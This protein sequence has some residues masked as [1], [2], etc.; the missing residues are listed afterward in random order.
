MTGQLPLV[1]GVRDN[2]VVSRLGPGADAGPRG[3]RTRAIAPARSSA[4]TCSIAASGWSV[5][6]D[7]YD[8]RVKRDPVGGAR[9]EAERRGEVVDAALSR[10]WTQTTH[11]FLPVGASLRSACALR[12]AAGVPAKAG[13]NAYD[14]E[15]AFADAQVA[16]LLEYWLGA[17]RARLGRSSPSPATTARDWAITASMTHG[18]LAYDSTLRVPLVLS[19]AAVPTRVVTAPVSLAESRAELLRAAGLNTAGPSADL[20]APT[21]AER[22]V[23][24]GDG[25]PARRGGMRCRYSQASAGS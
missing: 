24:R 5:G 16:R 11:P 8:D 17:R 7:T 23:Y 12:S 14:G 6:F 9:L 13:G 19:G 22:D 20:L 21:L 1:H 10:G 15:V 18:M 2:G 25:Y 3:F 4:P